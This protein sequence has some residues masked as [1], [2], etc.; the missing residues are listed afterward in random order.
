MAVSA[1]MSF[2]RSMSKVSCLMVSRASA[3][4]S[5]SRSLRVTRRKAEV[6]RDGS[7]K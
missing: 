7:S 6:K 4:R 2:K 3:M 5:Q 1:N